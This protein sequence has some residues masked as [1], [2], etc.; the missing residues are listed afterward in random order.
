MFYDFVVASDAELTE[1]LA[2][3]EGLGV[4]AGSEVEGFEDAAVWTVDVAL[5]GEVFWSARAVD[6][7]GAASD[8]APAFRLIVST[9]EP[10][11]EEILEELLDGATDPASG[12][13]CG[14]SLVADGG[15]SRLEAVGAMLFLLLPAVRRRR[16]R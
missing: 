10:S 9:G 1:V 13:D 2:G 6:G 11:V 14:S 7:T 4:L 3:G 15:V 5:M 12:C 8:W 16:R